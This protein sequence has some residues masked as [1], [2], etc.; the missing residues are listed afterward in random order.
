MVR[1][2]RGRAKTAPEQDQEQEST[3]TMTRIT[4]SLIAAALV[5]GAASTASAGAPGMNLRLPRVDRQQVHDARLARVGY[6][7]D[8]HTGT[9]GVAAPGRPAR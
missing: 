6:V 1:A 4:L 8:R 7:R 2:S 3:R 9:A 5:A